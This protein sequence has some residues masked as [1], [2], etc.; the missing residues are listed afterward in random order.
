MVR[1]DSLFGLFL[2]LIRGI[3]FVVGAFLLIFS[4]CA[5]CAMMHEPNSMNLWIGGFLV[6]LVMVVVI[7]FVLED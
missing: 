2:G 4:P 7:S 5:V 3:F 6:C 1:S